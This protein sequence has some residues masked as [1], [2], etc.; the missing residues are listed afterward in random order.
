MMVSL[1]AENKN[2]GVFCESNR[3]NQDNDGNVLQFLFECIQDGAVVADR[4]GKILYSHEALQTLALAWK[5]TEQKQKHILKD[6][7]AFAQALN[8][9]AELIIST[10]D[11]EII[12]NTVTNI[13]GQ[14]MDLY[15][16]M[17]YDVDYGKNELK[18][19]CQYSKNGIPE[20]LIPDRHKVE[21]AKRHDFFHENRKEIIVSH[22]DEMNP[23]LVSNGMAEIIH[24]HFQ[25]QSFFWYPFSLSQ[26]GYYCLAF[27]QIDRK[28]I[29][30]EN[31]M[32]FLNSALKLVEI[33]IQKIHY[34]TESRQIEETFKK[35]EKEKELILSSISELVV[36]YDQNMLIKWANSAATESTGKPVEQLIGRHCYEVWYDK[37]GPCQGCPVVDTLATGEKHKN[38]IYL[39]N[40]EF[41]SIK[42]FPVLDQDGTLLGAVQVAKNKTDS[43]KIE[44]EMARLER[45]NLVGE[46]AASF[47]HE[48][49]NPMATVRGFLQIL[50]GKD[51]CASYR[52][53]FDVMI[54]EIDRANSIISEFLAMAKHKAVDLQEQNLINIIESLFPLILAD[55]IH[56]DKSIELD[57]KEVP[58]VLVDKKET[59]QLI[60]NLVRNGLEAMAPG[61]CLTIKTYAEEEEVILAIQDQGKGIEPEVMNRL[62]IPFFTTKENGTGLG[63]AICYSIVQRHNAKLDVS[64]GAAGTTFF[65]RY[66]KVV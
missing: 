30:G 13:I 64:S 54:E 50:Y 26:K 36:Y 44:K 17:I 65:I 21:T 6:Q 52:D 25:V 58:N 46:M 35:S 28:R 42:A 14:T 3:S 7:L 59:H 48:I 1:S 29:L 32:E 38:E 57:L 19:E 4:E 9:L 47:G 40:G 66:K 51:E 41:W 39:P 24:N 45:L 55:A 5:Q 63:L 16:C 12:L 22:W 15:H 23:I 62:G 31:E 8:R 49:R 33:A 18:M 37:P 53:Y 11:T 43:D 20:I 60:L 56:T 2:E 34:L 27:D 10:A 61:G